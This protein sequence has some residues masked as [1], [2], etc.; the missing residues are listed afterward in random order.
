MNQNQ[1]STYP[2]A[3][4]LRYAFVHAQ[5]HE[6]IVL[7]AY[8]GFLREAEKLGIDA[9]QIDVFPVA[10]A[11]EIPLHCK[12]L[13]QTEGYAGIV[14]CALVVDGGIYRHDFVAST[15]VDA[16][17]RVQLD[18]ETPMFSVMLTPHHFHEAGPHY[19]FSP[20]IL[21]KK[22]PKL[23]TLASAQQKA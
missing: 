22:G 12:K 19:D 15:V 21:F 17:M 16:L 6:N 18:T 8:H 7:N 11:Y 20:N 13:A 3:S 9:S 10:G 14:A 4:Q 1:P 5:W 23:L 2:H